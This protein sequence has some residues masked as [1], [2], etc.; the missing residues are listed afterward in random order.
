MNNILSGRGEFL[1]DIELL[2]RN[3]LSLVR[4]IALEHLPQVEKSSLLH[5]DCSINNILLNEGSV[6]AFIDPDPIGGDGLYDLA[7]LSAS[8]MDISSEDY[9]GLILETY[10][11]KQPTQD[12]IKKWNVY[13]ILSL[14]RQVSASVK[15]KSRDLNTHTKLTQMVELIDSLSNV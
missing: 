8:L 2:D 11:G 13:K 5:G 12:E 3:R 14:I 7:Y 1:V 4:K 15:K 6:M 10:L 9:D